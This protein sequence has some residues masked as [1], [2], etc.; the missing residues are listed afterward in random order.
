MKIMKS[1]NPHYLDIFYKVLNEEFIQNQKSKADVNQIMRLI[2]Y[3]Y[4][5]EP[6]N[7]MKNLIRYNMFHEMLG[8]IHIDLV[9][10]TLASFITP[11]DPLLKVDTK[12]R[13]LMMTYFQKCGFFQLLIKQIDRVSITSVLDE[14]DRIS[15]DEEIQSWVRSVKTNEASN[16]KSKNILLALFQSFFNI[17][18]LNKHHKQP[19]QLY[20]NIQDIDLVSQRIRNYKKTQG[21]SKFGPLKDEFGKKLSVGSASQIV[22]RRSISTPNI[23]DI[24]ENEVG[25]EELQKYV[26]EDDTQNQPN[27]HDK[28]TIN[29]LDKDKY[30]KGNRR[31][32]RMTRALKLFQRA[33]LAIIASRLM[34]NRKGY[35]KSQRT[36]RLK[37]KCYP[38]HIKIIHPSIREIRKNHQKFFELS[39]KREKSSN[40]LIQLLHHCIVNYHSS[41]TKKEF[42]KK[43]RMFVVEDPIFKNLLF[44]DPSDPE[45]LIFKI[46]RQFIAKIEYHLENKVLFHSS[47]WGGQLFNFICE[48][49]DFFIEKK[50]DRT[51]FARQL[52]EYMSDICR[53]VNKGHTLYKF[54][55]DDE[56]Q[57]PD[58]LV[59]PS[60]G[61]IRMLISE[62]MFNMIL[63]DKETGYEAVNKMHDSTFHILMI[64][65][66]EKCHNNIYLAKF[67]KFMDI[68][69]AYATNQTLLNSFIKTNLFS[70]MA[71]FI[72]NHVQGWNYVNKIRDQYLWFLKDLI[73]KIENLHNRKNCEQF[74]SQLKRSLN[75]KYIKQ[76][77]NSGFNVDFSSL[78]KKVH[79]KPRNSQFTSNAEQQK[80]LAK[81]LKV[82]KPSKYQPKL[83]P[84]S[85][86]VFTS[87]ESSS[88]PLMDSGNPTSAHDLGFNPVNRGK[89]IALS[90][91]FGQ[92]LFNNENNKNQV[93]KKL[94]LKLH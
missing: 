20:A 93:N 44:F 19:E 24:S 2:Q 70:D 88:A 76:T 39:M 7:S 5:F 45:Q 94:N 35:M 63:V 84:K 27:H 60:F 81:K 9:K 52:R 30:D 55:E 11:G 4:L 48:N 61:D 67:S 37:I 22:S 59:V 1:C 85:K 34:L 26:Y 21:K 77:Y 14:V 6:E 91:E 8:N 31:R 25:D 36:M 12:E 71:E 18:L 58:N 56:V 51:E 50:E 32:I 33:T 90:P 17:K 68:F 38:E 16:L 53:L 74:L 73:L 92:R 43:M 65:S 13:N 66:M 23:L 72:K 78:R 69:L 54:R 3:F 42:S 46:F 41:E 10:E 49:I 82:P 47:Y 64:Q 89:P 75:W 62:V 83:Q 57:L 79:D 28:Q 15:K 86:N 87:I 40:N 80:S 29:L